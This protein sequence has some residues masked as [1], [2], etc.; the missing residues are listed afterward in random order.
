MD[1]HNVFHV[2]R[3]TCTMI[4]KTYR[5]L[6]QPNP[7]KIKGNLKFKVEKILDF[8]HNRHYSNGILYLV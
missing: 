3:L 2:D 7:I 6:P 8:K 5:K 1:L 4:N